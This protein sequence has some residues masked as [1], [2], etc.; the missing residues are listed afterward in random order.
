MFNRTKLSVEWNVLSPTLQS[1]PSYPLPTIS[2]GSSQNSLSSSLPYYTFLVPLPPLLPTYTDFCG[3]RVRD[4]WHSLP[5][6][7][8][9]FP[10]TQLRGRRRLMPAL[11]RQSFVISAWRNGWRVQSQQKGGGRSSTGQSLLG[12]KPDPGEVMRVLFHGLR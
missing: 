12:N 7:R 5:C 8:E 10:D 11:S 3:Q 4:R 1:D 6:T 9:L 2:C